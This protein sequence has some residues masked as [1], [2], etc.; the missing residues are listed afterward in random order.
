MVPDRLV[1]QDQ[2]PRELLRVSRLLPDCEQDPGP[3]GRPDAAP[4]QPPQDSFEA[5]HRDR[6]G[7]DRC[8]SCT[9][10]TTPEKGGQGM[11]RPV[12]VGRRPWALGS[13]SGRGPA[14]RG[15]RIR[16]V[17]GVSG[18]G[19]ARAGNRSRRRRIRR[20]DGSGRGHRVHR[21]RARHE[22]RQDGDQGDGDRC[23]HSC[24]PPEAFLGRAETTRGHPRFPR[25][26]PNLAPMAT[27]S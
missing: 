4:K 17:T 3:G 1:V 20:R 9:L 27:E 5:V 11:A 7:Q 22:D 24:S 16:A 2:G 18:G 10:P 14:R 15:G 23:L 26:C 6:R 25:S 21:E 8:D 12:P 13:T 19:I